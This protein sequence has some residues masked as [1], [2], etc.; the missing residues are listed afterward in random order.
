MAHTL[1]CNSA[2]RMHDSQAYRKMDV[3]PNIHLPV[4]SHNLE[5]K[6]MFLSFQTGFNFTSAAVVCVLL[7]VLSWRVCISGLELSSDTA[8]LRVLG[9][10]DCHK[11]LSIYFDHWVDAAC[12]ACHQLGLLSSDLYAVGCGG[13]VQTLN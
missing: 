11:R 7:S 10:C 2:V 6:E 12:V 3:S 9:T 1:L 8:E 4:V 5:L 13:L